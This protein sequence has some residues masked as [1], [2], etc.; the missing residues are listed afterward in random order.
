MKFVFRRK[1]MLLLC[2]LALLVALFS[3]GL[4]L[5][6][7]SPAYPVI[8]LR[9]NWDLTYPDGERIADISLEDIHFAPVVMGDV[10]ELRHLLPEEEVISAAIQIKTRHASLEVYVDDELVYA[11]GMQYP[12]QGKMTPGAFHFVPLPAGYGGRMMTLRLWSNEDDAFSSL[13]P[14]VIGHIGDLY[15]T[16]IQ[17]GAFTL[18]ASL[19]LIVMGILLGY[20]FLFLWQHFRL[21]IRILSSGLISFILGLYMLSYYNLPDILSSD[22][23]RNDLVEY[24]SLFL[25]PFG[26]MS[27]LST[28]IDNKTLRNTV[29]IP[30]TILNFLTVAA[31]VICHVTGLVFID[32]FVTPVHI[33][34]L[35]QG[36]LMTAYM[37]ATAIRRRSRAELR[38]EWK[39]S[40]SILVAG[41][42]IM[43]VS[44]MIDIARYNFIRYSGQ[45][46]SEYDNLNIMTV[47]AFIFV[48]TLILNFFYY[49]IEE[50]FEEET[51]NRLS[52]LAY[53][54]PLTDMANR[55][56][57]EQILR[58]I[59]TRPEKT[60]FTIISMD[61]NSLK[62]INDT[63]GHAAGDRMLAECA[64]ILSRVFAKAQLV[65]R[66]GG[67]E[68]LAYLD[69]TDRDIVEEMLAALEE[70]LKASGRDASGPYS[71]SYGYAMSTETYSSSVDETYRLADQRMYDMKKAH[72]GEGGSRT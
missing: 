27:F 31:M 6:A 43:I 55:A 1:N 54:D 29:F 56:R 53:T 38:Q 4:T 12:E 22:I 33:I 2:V 47:G 34:M 24:I 35:V 21:E 39:I 5:M 70:E 52:G 37:I 65:G 3:R 17:S 71:M 8:N 15:R 25:L 23:M 64:G 46:V 62:Q 44:G 49:H 69:T 67:D 30:V 48:F 50:V 7:P 60:P 68:F 41:F 51:V 13:E 10:Y 63:H 45:G 42:I 16:Y 59:E 61:V 58:D 66:M 57:C 28:T 9:D 32:K 40:Q 20:I 14:V 72:H 26:F 11:D 18:V 19:F 36:V